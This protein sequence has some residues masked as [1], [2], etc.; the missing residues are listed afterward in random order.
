MPP[1]H[2]A[3]KGLNSLGVGVSLINPL[4]RAK[5]CVYQFSEIGKGKC[6]CAARFCRK[7]FNSI[8]HDTESYFSGSI[9]VLRNVL[10]GAYWP[11]SSIFC[12]ASESFGGVKFPERGP[13]PPP[14]GP[15]PVGPL[16]AGAVP[17]AGAAGDAPGGRRPPGL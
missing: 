13:L 9:S 15:V 11:K 5:K 14:P 2:L 6:V 3:K 10:Q 17:G 8:S 16:S 12:S 1:K 7:R 4:K